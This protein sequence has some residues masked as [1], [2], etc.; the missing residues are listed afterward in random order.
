MPNITEGWRLKAFQNRLF[1]CDA[2]PLGIL[3]MFNINLSYLVY[4]LLRAQNSPE[5]P[6]GFQPLPLGTSPR[7]ITLVR[8]GRVRQTGRARNTRGIITYP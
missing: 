4:E 2:M 5:G 6:P 3:S 7:R 1:P 8:P